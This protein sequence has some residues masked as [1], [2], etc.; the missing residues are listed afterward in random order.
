MLNKLKYNS[1]IILFF[2]FASAVNAQ[3]AKPEYVGRTDMAK[4]FKQI[5]NWFI[6]TPIYSL[7]VTHA[8]YESYKTTIPVEKAAGYFKK[9]KNNYHSFLIG[10]HTIQNKTYKIV[11]DSSEK[12]ILVA[13]PDKLIWNTYTTSDYDTLLKT[14]ATIK[15]TTVGNDKLYR[16]DFNSESPIAW[17]EFLINPNGLPKEIVW[18]YNQEIKKDEE[19]EAS[20]KVKPRVSITFSNYNSSAVLDY[21]KE[22]NEGIYFTNT[23]NKI[24]LTEKYK[25]YKLND[26]RVK[27]N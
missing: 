11:I 18:Y 1:C 25:N 21:N 12:I 24:S 16:M 27:L 14:C 8:S 7:S 10:I 17:Y 26:Q 15:V 4:V 13:N 23:N 19:D 5:N 3:V 2:F 22:F 9:N 6:N 20:E